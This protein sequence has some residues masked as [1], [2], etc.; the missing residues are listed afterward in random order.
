MQAF[1]NVDQEQKISGLS[2]LYEAYYTE[3]ASFIRTKVGRGPP[4]VE[5]II[6]QIFLEYSQQSTAKERAL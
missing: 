1:T 3:L 6:Q 2:R 4:E 5:D